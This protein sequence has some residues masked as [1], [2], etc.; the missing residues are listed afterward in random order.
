MHRV[1]IGLLIL[2]VGLTHGCDGSAPESKFTAP[3]HG[4]KVLELPD[5][6]GFVELKT[7]RDA[8]TKGAGKSPV[9]SRITA[10]F[11]QADATTAMS[12]APTDVKVTLG[13]AGSGPAVSLT[14]QSAAPGMFASDPGD[15]PDDLRGQIDLQCAGKPVQATFAFR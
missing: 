13:A 15:Y 14:P 10:Y 8:P 11:F 4:G 7:E 5:S 2:S 12:P 3:P 6:L 1:L 9:K